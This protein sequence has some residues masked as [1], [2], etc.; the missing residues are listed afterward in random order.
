MTAQACL[1]KCTDSDQNRPLAP[2]DMLIWTFKGGSKACAISTKISCSAGLQMFFTIGRPK[3]PMEQKMVGH[4]VKW[5]AQAYQTNHSWLWVVYFSY[6]VTHWHRQLYAYMYIDCWL[7]SK[8][9]LKWP[10]KKEDQLSLNA[11][12]EYCNCSKG[13]ILQSFWHSLSYHLLL[14]SLFCLFF[15]VAA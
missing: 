10:L 5:S 14:R 1:C 15:W 11:G 12:Q 3:W 6:T 2:L 13:S 9:C 4:F 7:Y 8:T